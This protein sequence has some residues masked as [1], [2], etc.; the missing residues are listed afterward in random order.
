MK[1]RHPI[2]RG[3]SYEQ[4]LHHYQVEKRIAD[5]LRNSSSRDE[6]KAIYRTMYDELFRE[7]PWHPRLVRRLDE[8]A[9]KGFIERKWT[10]VREYVDDSTVFAE[11]GPGD[12]RFAFHV[13]TV[14]RQVYGI[15]ISDQSGPSADHPDNFRLIVYDGFTLD[16]GDDSIDVVFSDQLLE[17]LHPD[18][19][20]HHLGLARRVLK[21]GGVYVMRTPHACTGPHDVSQLFSATP[22][23]FHLKEWTF[24]ELFAALREA[25]FRSAIGSLMI[26]GKLYRVPEWL[27]TVVERP[28]RPAPPRLRDAIPWRLMSPICIVA[29]K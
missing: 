26:R 9:T 13:A 8:R 4:A 7:V 27:L 3:W 11:F 28:L 19:M 29:T 24:T 20:L 12:C 21:T 5:R 10:L 2:P 23:G 22:Q 14:A 1:L 17:H 15:D 18:D 6:R 16:L 25:G